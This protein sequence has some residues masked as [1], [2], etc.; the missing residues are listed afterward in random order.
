MG[1]AMGFANS[2]HLHFK[3]FSIFFFCIMIIEFL[4]LVISMPIILEG[5]PRSVISHLEFKSLFPLLF[6]LA[7][8]VNSNKLSTHNIMI[9]K[10]DQVCLSY[11]ISILFYLFLFFFH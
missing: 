3:M 9:S 7:D 5:S 8:E 1:I 11:L 2:M 4:S 10:R 6:D